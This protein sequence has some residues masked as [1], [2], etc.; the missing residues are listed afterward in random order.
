MPGLDQPLDGLA[1]LDDV[2]EVVLGMDVGPH[3]G[4]PTTDSV[5]VMHA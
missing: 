4:V 1:D 5:A 2:D 3:P